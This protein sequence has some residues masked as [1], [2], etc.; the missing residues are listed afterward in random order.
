[1]S[2]R[3]S[4]TGASYSH[5]RRGSKKQ[6]ATGTVTAAD[7]SV[8]LMTIFGGESNSLSKSSEHA[9]KLQP[10]PGVLPRRGVRHWQ[11]VHVIVGDAGATRGTQITYSVH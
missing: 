3:R 9:T 1:M 2:F 10:T 8:V 5:Y 7:V 11:L 6:S 4:D